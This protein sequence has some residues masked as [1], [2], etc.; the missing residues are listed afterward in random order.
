MKS[1]FARPPE[2]SS[3]EPF[4]TL[5][6]LL[7]NILKPQREKNHLVVIKIHILQKLRHQKLPSNRDKTDSYSKPKRTI[8]RPLST[9]SKEQIAKT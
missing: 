9:L 8:T 7:K 4:K 2:Q 5:P 3:F 1:A 6:P